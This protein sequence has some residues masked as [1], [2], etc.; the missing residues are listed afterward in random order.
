MI[1]S[2][3]ILLMAAVIVPALISFPLQAQQG[4]GNA[5]EYRVGPSDVVNLSFYG[6]PELN[7][8]GIRIAPDGTL[9]YLQAT[10]VPVDGL[11]LRHVRELMEERLK[12]FYNN[13]RL[14]ITPGELNSKR[15]VILGKVLDKGVFTLNRPTT[16]LEALARSRGVETG[17]SEQRTV[18]LA[19]MERSFIIRKGK[20]LDVDLARLYYEGDLSQ[21]VLLQDGDYIYIASNVTNEFYVFGEVTQPGT[22]GM[23][24]RMTVVGAVTRRE[25][26]TGDAWQER[27]LLVRG[28]LT[29]PEVRVV[30]VRD[31]LKGQEP[32]VN[33]EPGDIIYVSARPWRKVEEVLK[34]ALDAFLTSMA[35]TWTGA[36]VPTIINNQLLPDTDWKQRQ[37]AEDASAANATDAAEEEQD[38]ADALVTPQPL[39]P[40]PAGD[41]AP[42]TP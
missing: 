30:N 4:E 42:N 22:Q 34:S 10:S 38:A 15:Y 16:V 17:L 6:R 21:N 31:V 29:Q 27:V 9:S 40:T 23:T 28:S 14:I 3:F 13:P 33:V 37:D 18:E 11:T 36:N 7:R 19:D 24:P 25:G 2:R 12:Q 35:S 20:R 32:D 41:P 26:F 8:T 1:Y 5:P 39:A